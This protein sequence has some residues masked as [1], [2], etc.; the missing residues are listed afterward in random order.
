MTSPTSLDQ[1]L[2][3]L[4]TYQSH[5]SVPPLGGTTE[6]GRGGKWDR[7]SLETGRTESR[8]AFGMG[9]SE[10]LGTERAVGTGDV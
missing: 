3:G 5:Q 6:T 10:I 4:D 7:T 2:D 8:I 9:S 1:S